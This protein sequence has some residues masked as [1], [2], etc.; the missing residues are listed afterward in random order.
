M[1][2]LFN[3]FLAVILSTLVPWALGTEFVSMMV[4]K[5][6]EDTAKEAAARAQ[7]AAAA[8]PTLPSL[9]APEVRLGDEL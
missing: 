2:V 7:S 5:M 9:D 1:D 3:A 6:N 4:V 8:L